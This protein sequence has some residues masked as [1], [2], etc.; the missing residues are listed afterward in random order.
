[1]KDFDKSLSDLLRVISQ[2]MQ[3][4][5]SF[6]QSLDTAASHATPELRREMEAILKSVRDGEPRS[7][8]FQELAVRRQS[9]NLQFLATGIDMNDK[10]GGDLSKILDSIAD[11]ITE[12]IHL[13][14]DLKTTTSS[15]RTSSYLLA[16][17]PIALIVI[18]NLLVPGFYQDVWHSKIGLTMLGAGFGLCILGFLMLRLIL[19]RAMA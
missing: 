7:K 1:M 13:E 3:A 12:R 17:L 18:I 5:L 2:S 14:Q 8:A 9:E 11:G 10:A 6:D 19:K 15:A 16:F 4:G